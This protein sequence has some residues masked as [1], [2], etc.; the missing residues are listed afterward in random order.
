MNFKNEPETWARLDYEIMMRGF[1]KPYGD[2]SKLKNDIE[3]FTAQN[4]KIIEFDCT[5][6]TSFD[7]IHFELSSKIDYINGTG[8]AWGCL[9][10]SL[11]ELEIKENGL[12]VL[13]DNFDFISYKMREILIDCFVKSARRH[14]LFNEK[15]I[16]LI[17]VDRNRKFELKPF[18]ATNFCWY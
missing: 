1:L 3:W 14:V 11:D 5:E 4:F 16:I 13:F 10:E 8:Y 6:W 12:V 2:Y 17:K 7:R 18:G 9:D 15:L